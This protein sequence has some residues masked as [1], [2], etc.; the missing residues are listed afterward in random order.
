MAEEKAVPDI[1]SDWFGSYVNALGV[2]LVLSKT[3]PPLTP[4]ANRQPEA[5]AV[6][7]FSLENWKTML[8]TARKQLKK[9]EA[10]TITIH[11][12]KPLMESLG[13]TEADW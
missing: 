1:Y 5:M 10:D 6:L 12:P 7:R 3:Q 2:V 13:L 4:G 11:L 9:H 8:M